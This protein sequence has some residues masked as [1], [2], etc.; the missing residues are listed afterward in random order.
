[1]K[2]LITEG[3]RVFYK[4]V[5]PGTVVGFTDGG[6]AMIELDTGERVVSYVSE[7]RLIP[8]DLDA[9]DGE[10]PQGPSDYINDR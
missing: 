6:L 3:D 4:R 9:E 2:R 5:L 1:M 10:E 8:N 7:L